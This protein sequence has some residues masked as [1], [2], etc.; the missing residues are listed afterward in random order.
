ML[1]PDKLARVFKKVEDDNWDFRSF[2]K[3]QDEKELDKLVH[4]MHKE[5]FKD[6][7]CISC[8]NCCR[9][10][11]PI[12]EDKDIPA[13]SSKLGISTEV[14]KRTYLKK[15]EDGRMRI[16]KK[17]CPFLTDKGCSI[18]DCRPEACREYPFTDKTDIMG[19]LITMVM[20][21]EICPVVY[22]IFERLKEYY[23]DE[24]RKDG[25]YS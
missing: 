23:A 11:V 12:L 19:R 4:K 6:T 15:D 3:G 17:P 5:L 18:Y 9:K 22:E 13:I 7:D 1:S 10:I 21:C 24:Y 14:F 2:L 25:I 16:N 8:S 20:N